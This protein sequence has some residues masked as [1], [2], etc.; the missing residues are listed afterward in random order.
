[1]KITFQETAPEQY[2][3]YVDG[4]N[5]GYIDESTIIQIEFDK[6]LIVLLGPRDEVIRE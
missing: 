5:K 1:M 3:I 2:D 6:K 4:V